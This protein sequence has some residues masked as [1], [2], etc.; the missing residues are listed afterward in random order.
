MFRSQPVYFFHDLLHEGDATMDWAGR[1]P[2][3]GLPTGPL[4]GR[5]FSSYLSEQPSKQTA[6]VL[7]VATGTS[8]GVPPVL[9]TYGNNDTPTMPV[10]RGTDV[11]LPYRARHGIQTD[12]GAVQ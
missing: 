12:G 2:Q 1:S 10:A 9:Y 5:G 3:T 8:R 6:F 11:Y 7:D 4:C